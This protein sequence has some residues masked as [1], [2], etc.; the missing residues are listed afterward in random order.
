MCQWV[1]KGSKSLSKI[2]VLRKFARN[3]E[4]LEGSFHVRTE[5]RER[6]CPPPAHAHRHDSAAGSEGDGAAL[7]L[8]VGAGAGPFSPELKR[9]LAACPM[10]RLR[11]VDVEGRLTLVAVQLLAGNAARLEQ[12]HVANSTPGAAAAAREGDQVRRDF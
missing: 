8:R 3:L 7:G 2:S 1:A 4:A 5:E 6:F 9:L 11:A 12:L 10:R